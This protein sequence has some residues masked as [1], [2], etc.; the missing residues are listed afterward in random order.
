MLHIAEDARF[1]HGPPTAST[2]CM[3]GNGRTCR[4]MSEAVSWS[5]R[6]AWRRYYERKGFED[7]PQRIFV[8]ADLSKSFTT[9]HFGIIAR[10]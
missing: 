2:K 1:L 7:P 4:E 3:A 5:L 8:L 10:S 9:P 6:L